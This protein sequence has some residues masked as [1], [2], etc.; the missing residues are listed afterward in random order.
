MSTVIAI[1]P[2]HAA[3]DEP[4]HVEQA[5]RLQAV[6]AALN[7]SGLRGSLLE[8]PAR[9]ATEAELRAVHRERMV[10]IVRWS[11]EGAESWLDHDTYT[12]PATWD[13]ATIAAGTAIAVV[14]AVVEGWASNGFALV[15][16]PGHHA[17][18]GA[19]MGFCLF[20]NIAVAARYALDKLGLKR[21]AIVDFDVHHGNGTQDIFIDDD[22][23]LFCSSHGT[24]LYPGTG[25]EREIG[26]GRGVGATLNLPLP[27]GVGD[28]GFARLYD[29][30]VV[31]AIRRF[32]PEIILVSA[33]FDGHWADPLGPLTL[34]VAGYAGLT[35]RLKALADE[36]CNG[37]IV[38]VL[39]GGYNLKAL[40]ACVVA[41]LNV[42]CGND[43]GKD[44]YGPSGE[45]EP[46]VSALIARIQQSH[47]LL[48]P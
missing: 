47:P 23:V 7:A 3:H 14:E 46:D 29:E 21:V 16:P 40:A 41:S 25:A 18:P 19:S 13:A 6:V 37:R 20:N 15:R 34:S 33:G 38:L 30:I 31:P 35:A 2:R 32:A 5:A 26:V 36:I 42:L 12:T 8:I 43:A 44:P 27:H 9:A 28:G 22:R 1:H 24:P 11:A 4:R 39:E 45:S 48:A 17:T 10:D